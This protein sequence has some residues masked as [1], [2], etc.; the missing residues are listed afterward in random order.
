MEEVLV[1]DSRPYPEL[2]HSSA[3]AGSVLLRNDF[4][5][6]APN[7][8]DTLDHQTGLHVTRSGGSAAFSTLSIRGSTA[9]QV[10]IFVDGIHLN[11]AGGGPVDL[12]RIPLGNIAR[13]E[14][15]RGS[16]PVYFG[17]SSIGGVLSIS[18]LEAEALELRVSAGGGSF[19]ERHAA[20]FFSEQQSNWNLALGMDYSGQEGNFTYRNDNGTRFDSSDDRTITRQNNAFDQANLLL[21]SRIK[22]PC[23]GCDLS[24]T[25]LDWFFYRNQGVAGLGQFETERASS[26]QIDN[27]NALK[28][29]AL[30]LAGRIDWN[31]L[32]AFRYSK[33]SFSDPLE[34][35]G[36]NSADVEDISYAPSLMSYYSAEIS[37]WLN[38]NGQQTYRYEQLQPSEGSLAAAESQ[39]HMASV[40]Q[41]AQFLIEKAQLVITPSA[42]IESAYSTQNASDEPANYSDSDDTA[43]SYRLSLTNKSIPDTRLL[44]NGGSA[45]RFP[46]LFELFGNNGKVL[47]NTGLKKETSYG[48]EAGV[49]YESTMLPFPYRLRLELFGFYTEMRDLIQFVQSAQNVSI[50]E[51][52]DSARIW[53]VESGLRSDLFGHLRLAANYTY[54]NTR[55]TGDVAAKNGNRL[56]MRP[57]SQWYARAEAYFMRVSEFNEISFYTEAEWSAGNYLDNANLVA[58]GSRL[59]INSGFALDLG[60]ARLSFAAN[61]LSG[62][63]T[64]DLAGYPLPGRNFHFDIS[65]KI[66]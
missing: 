57:A 60:G 9:D 48:A 45:S 39:R 10:Q 44:I 11:S 32:A 58:V 49:I 33:N 56:P 2:L 5:D 51:N 36:L 26:K 4:D 23:S 3:T 41:E 64:Q 22:L 50:A 6:A 28:L 66:L 52:I 8:T 47:G 63:Q 14:I 35:I 24:L 31:L 17:T 20:L 62:E 15:Y 43:V 12:S 19:G 25:V 42:G 21:K 46:S 37:N 34:E 38:W 55:N 65:W 30:G 54:M 1:Q 13:M 7:L 29:D 40:S 53:G 27:L 59:R 61:N 16:A 18:T